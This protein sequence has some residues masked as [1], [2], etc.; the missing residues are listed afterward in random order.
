LSTLKLKIEKLMGIKGYCSLRVLRH[1]LAR[2]ISYKTRAAISK[3]TSKEIA[4]ERIPL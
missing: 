4:K 2:V 3:R 1:F